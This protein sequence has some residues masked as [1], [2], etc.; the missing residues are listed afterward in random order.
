MLDIAEWF[1]RLRER[2][3]AY[4]YYPEPT[5]SHIVT[6]PELVD[7]ARRIF[8][9]LGVKVHTDYRFLGGCIGTT[10]GAQRYVEEKV[11]GW[12]ASVQSLSCAAVRSPQA[13]LAGFTKSLQ[14]EWSYV[15]RVVKCDPQ[16]YAPLRT[17][18]R[19][20]FTPKLLGREV[21]D[22]LQELL[23][24]SARL[25]GWAYGT[26]WLGHCLPTLSL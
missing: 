17:A 10:E 4:G 23:A 14:H 16:V 19:T 6:R 21:S 22:D 26:R 9:P 18:I 2:G 12:V 7:Q 5:K 24:L 25:G 1:R 13:A 8:S 15:Q 3:P 11:K 20:H